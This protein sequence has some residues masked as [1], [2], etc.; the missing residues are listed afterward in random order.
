[1]R[2]RE[3]ASLFLASLGKW[4]THFL[5]QPHQREITPISLTFREAGEE[6]WHYLQHLPLQT[7]NCKRFPHAPPFSPNLT[8]SYVVTN[9]HSTTQEVS[10][11]LSVTPL[12]CTMTFWSGCLYCPDRQLWNFSCTQWTCLHTP[13]HRHTHA[14]SLLALW[15][16]LLLSLSPPKGTQQLQQQ[17]EKLSPSVPFW[18][19]S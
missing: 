11:S 3:L 15:L 17:W 1:M 9:T 14:F 12:N 6:F 2:A 18:E 5:L 8:L 7:G 4:R 16:C 13:H 10:S 19:K